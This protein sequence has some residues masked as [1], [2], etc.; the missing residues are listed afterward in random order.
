M[1]HGLFSGANAYFFDAWRILKSETPRKLLVFRIEAYYVLL[2]DDAMSVAE[3][4]KRE[5][6]LVYGAY[7][8]YIA[9]HAM[10]K[11]LTFRELE[12]MGHSIRYVEE[13]S[14]K[15][16][17]VRLPDPLERQAGASLG[18]TYTIDPSTGRRYLGRRG[19]TSFWWDSK[20][21][22]VYMRIGQFRW[23][24]QFCSKVDWNKNP[25]STVSDYKSVN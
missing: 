13:G 9:F 14:V 22:A 4:L 1:E 17:K 6:D 11:S 21:R 8:A 2:N 7:G 24:G 12:Q 5:K 18:R 23:L 16:T 15:A 10:Y 19:D 25:D 20:E 3:S